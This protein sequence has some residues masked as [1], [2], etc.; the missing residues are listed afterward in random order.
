MVPA[1][2]VAQGPKTRVVNQIWPLRRR[3][4]L[5]AREVLNWKSWRND[6]TVS[7]SWSLNSGPEMR[8]YD[9]DSSEAKHS[10]SLVRTLSKRVW[11]LYTG[12]RKIYCYLFDNHGSARLM[13]SRDRLPRG[14]SRMQWFMGELIIYDLIGFLFIFNIKNFTRCRRLPIGGQ[15]HLQ[16]HNSLGEGSG[17]NLWTIL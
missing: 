8:L 1:V 14:T 12:T 11:V 4:S 16:N 7:V 5:I 6:R 13:L 10:N 3:V 9:G 17:T 15:L 2:Q